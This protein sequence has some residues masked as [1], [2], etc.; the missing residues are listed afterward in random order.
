[1]PKLTYNAEKHWYYIDDIWVPS[2]TQIIN[3]LNDFDKI[4]PQILKNKCEWGKSIDVMCEYHLDGC[5]DEE[6]L[7]DEQKRVLKQFKLFIDKEACHLNFDSCIT[8]YRGCNEKLKYAGES[9]IIIPGQAVIDI[10]TRDL[11][12]LTDP[13]QLTGYN[14]IYDPK[15]DYEHWILSLFE[16]KYTFKQVNNT[17]ISRKQSY[18]RFRYMLDKVWNDIDFKQKIKVWKEKK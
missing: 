5:L 3:P 12:P 4:P 16:D 2:V 9:D 6:S 14:C 17:K 7:S 18:S 10:K 11:N 13:L 15:N 1:M 8:K